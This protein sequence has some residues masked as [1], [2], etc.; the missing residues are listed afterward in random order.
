MET[1]LYEGLLTGSVS[2]SSR[3]M[4][5]LVWGESEGLFYRLDEAPKLGMDVF[6]AGGGWSGN[7]DSFSTINN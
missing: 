3:G 4:E 2:V 5:E 6:V 1:F 7:L